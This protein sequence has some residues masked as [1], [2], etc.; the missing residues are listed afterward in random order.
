L[1]SVLGE[2]LGWEADSET[3]DELRHAVGVHLK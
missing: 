3:L 2:R 1:G